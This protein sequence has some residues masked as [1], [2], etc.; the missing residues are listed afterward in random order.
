MN[1]KSLISAALIASLSAVSHAGLLGGSTWDGWAQFNSAPG[2]DKEGNFNYVD[3]G[4]GGQAFDA[5]YLFY[6]VSGNTVHLGLQT[7]FDVE[8]GHQVYGNKHY[9]AGDLFL[10]IDGVTLGDSSSYEFAVDFGL[11]HCGWSDRNNGSCAETVHDAGVYSVS[12]YDD[13]VYAGHTISLPYAMDTGVKLANLLSNE[14][15][16]GLQDN[17]HT[18]Y[19]RQVSFDISQ[20]GLVGPLTVDAH[21]TMSC[22]NDA[23]DGYATVTEPATLA[24]LA[25]GIIGLGLARRKEK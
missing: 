3:P 7:G 5:E 16:S 2:E 14:A 18:S 13:D 25:I 8:T 9:W 12:S 4:Y 11:G 17:G 22:G 6:K 20:L 21:W 23:V 15:G 1:I 19:F 24:L 10:S